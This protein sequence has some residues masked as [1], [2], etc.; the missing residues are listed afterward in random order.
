VGWPLRTSSH[1][2]AF[3]K[4]SVCTGWRRP[5]GCLQLQII[6]R[7]RA[8][9]YRAFWREMTYEDKAFY[10]DFWELWF[11][12]KMQHVYTAAKTHT[13]SLRYRLFFAKELSISGSFAENDLQFIRHSL[14]LRRPVAAS[15][16]LRL[17][18]LGPCVFQKFSKISSPRT[19]VLSENAAFV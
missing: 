8:T 9:D 4:C 18:I 17:C 15:W 16:R 11:F 13:M 2:C 10:K 5:I 1:L 7:K 3:R 6:F 19:C 12:Q 14:C